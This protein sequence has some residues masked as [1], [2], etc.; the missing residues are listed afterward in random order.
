MPNK[1]CSEICCLVFGIICR[2]PE[3]PR[4]MIF[5]N[6][7]KHV[8]LSIIRQ[9]HS[10]LEYILHTYIRKQRIWN[11]R[12]FKSYTS[13]ILQALFLVRST[14]DTGLLVLTSTVTVIYHF[15][16]LAL[17]G[18]P[19]Q[20]TYRFIFFLLMKCYRPGDVH[21]LKYYRYATYS[22]FI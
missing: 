6:F 8:Y 15:D 11:Y 9:K 2:V 20:L 13:V 14:V 12:S 18:I 22:Y 10:Q 7:E 17:D 19:T 21:T 16:L 3:R 1:I 4:K 5:Q